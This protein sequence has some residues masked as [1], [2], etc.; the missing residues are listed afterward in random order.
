LYVC[1]LTSVLLQGRWEFGAVVTFSAKSQKYS[2]APPRLSPFFFR[3]GETQAPADLTEDAVVQK[4]KKRRASGD[5]AALGV[6]QKEAYYQA[7]SLGGGTG[8][9]GYLTRDKA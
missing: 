4:P 8:V 2:P 6:T 1:I 3:P 7:P 5:H 9:S